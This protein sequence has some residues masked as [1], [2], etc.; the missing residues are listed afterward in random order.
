MV[1][2]VDTNKISKLP[3]PCGES[4]PTIALAPHVIAEVLLRS[5][6]G[7]A[8]I[9]LNAYEGKFG[10]DLVHAYESL[11]DLSDLEIASFAP[12]IEPGEQRQIQNDLAC[13]S[14]GLKTRARMIKDSNLAFC[15]SMFDS[16]QRLRRIIRDQGMN[17]TKCQS[18]SAALADLHSFHKDLVVNSLTN[19]QQRKFRVSDSDVLYESVMNNPYFATGF[20]ALLYYI[21]SWSRLWADQTLNQDPNTNR[22]DWADLTL[23]FYAGD[24][25]TILTE[26]VGL[27]KAIRTIEPN[28]RVRA[29]GELS[30]N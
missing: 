30:P 10:L 23:A 29:R 28:G 2:I 4:T 11:L 9:R 18:I 1:L 5:N 26:D 7:P 24:G 8:L 17:I 25:D 12:F 20:K 19:G 27:H 21:L 13:F 22:D 3:D 16:A 6:P 15:G 14:D